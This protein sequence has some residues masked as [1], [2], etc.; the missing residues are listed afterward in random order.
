MIYLIIILMVILY[1]KLP[2]RE[3][4]RIWENLKKYDDSKGYTDNNPKTK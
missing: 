1:I 4:N 2:N 3:E